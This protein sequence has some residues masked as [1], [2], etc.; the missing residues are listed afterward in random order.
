MATS[1]KALEPLL[2]G[3]DGAPLPPPVIERFRA[4]ARADTQ[5]ERARAMGALAEAVRPRPDA[6]AVVAHLANSDDPFAR[7]LALEIAARLPAPL[8]APLPAT[9][10]PLLRDRLPGHLKLAAVS[11]VLRSAGASDP[12]AK[13]ALRAFVHGLGPAKAL[14]RLDELRRRVAGSD[15]LEKMYDQM[16]ASVPMVCPRCRARMT[17]PEMVK[18]LWQEHRLIIDRDRVREP[19]KVVRDWVGEYARAGRAEMLDRCCELAQQLDPEAGLDRVH[20]MLLVAG[21]DDAEARASVFEQAKRRQATICPHC[22]ALVPGP[23]DGE[24]SALPVGRGRLACQGYSVTLAERGAVS[25]LT[26]TTPHATAYDGPEPGRYFTWPGVQTLV[27]APLVTAALALAV[28]SNLSA[29]LVLLLVV[30]TLLVAAVLDLRLRIAWRRNADPTD[31]AIDHAWTFLVPPLV[32]ADP[33][34]EGQA[35]LASLALASLGRGRPENR[36]RLLDHAVRRARAASRECCIPGELLALARLQLSDA[37]Q[38]NADP[39]ALLAE[40][41]GACLAGELPLRFGEMLLASEEATSLNRGERARLRVLLAGRAFEAGLGVWDLQ[42]LGLVVPTLGTIINTDDVRQLARLRLVWR[43]KPER[44]WA[45]C[46]PAATA[47]DIARYPVIGGQYLVKRPDLLLFQPSA[48]ETG[49]GGP[50]PPVLVCADGLGFR[51]ALVSEPDEGITVKPRAG[52]QGSGHELL[53]GSARFVYRG[54]PSGVARRLKA[55]K[56]YYFEELLPQAEAAIEER[57][58]GPLE[59][60]LAQK[61]ATCPECGNDLVRRTGALGLIPPQPAEA[62]GGDDGSASSDQVPPSQPTQAAN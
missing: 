2:V 49:E 29:P 42:E 43:L 7:R 41:V 53:F 31:R 44:P 60:L 6:A 39:V 18:H 56:R 46:G 57:T 8:P 45:A 27:T 20:R 15:A 19:W 23:P 32:A 9:L 48:D 28:G 34:P 22:Y 52:W 10:A 26:V 33:P 17:R 5:A 55:W 3:R 16:D 58:P 47:F 35:F 25:R 51:D 30:V 13:Q 4:A 36:E 37:R 11:A 24:A 38:R 21:V 62:Q 12:V 14:E 59:G 40:H 54:D 61:L 50:A 1:W